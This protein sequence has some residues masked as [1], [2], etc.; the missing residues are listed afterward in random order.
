M[1]P[2]LQDKVHLIVEE[3]WLLQITMKP[4]ELSPTCDQSKSFQDR[5]LMSARKPTPERVNELLRKVW[6]NETLDK[7]LWDL[8][9]MLVLR[10]TILRYICSL[11]VGVLN[12]PR[13]SRNVS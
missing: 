2:D 6:K 12:L 7:H 10:S 3:T 8:C 1:Y 11:K 4:C 13:I 9:I 5:I